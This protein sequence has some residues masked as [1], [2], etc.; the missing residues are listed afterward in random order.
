MTLTLEQKKAIINYVLTEIGKG[1]FED[2]DKGLWPDIEKGENFSAYRR[3]VDAFVL[4]LRQQALR[5]LKPEEAAKSPRWMKWNQVDEN[6]YQSGKYRV[7]CEGRRGGIWVPYF[8]KKELEVPGS[9]HHVNSDDAKDACEQ[10]VQS[11]KG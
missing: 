3:A 9:L 7:V 11:R 6:E 10:H 2:D 8:G 4:Q 5:E 1:I